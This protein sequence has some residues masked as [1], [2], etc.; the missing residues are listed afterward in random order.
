MTNFCMHGSDIWHGLQRQIKSLRLFRL[1]GVTF[2]IC[3]FT[4]APTVRA[5][6]IKPV[7]RTENQQKPTHA[8]AVTSSMTKTHG[9]T[10][11]VDRTS[12]IV[13]YANFCAQILATSMKNRASP[14]KWSANDG[15]DLEYTYIYME[16]KERKKQ[17][18]PNPV[19]AESI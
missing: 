16:Q 13:F 11:S 17:S 15:D 19:R 1:F 18:S 14:A 4:L 8:A 5:Q 7:N 6:R 12:S 10:Y 9:N 2:C 3:Y